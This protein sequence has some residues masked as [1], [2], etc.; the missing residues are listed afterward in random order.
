MWLYLEDR[1]EQSCYQ[2]RFTVDCPT[3]SIQGRYPWEYGSGRV[4]G[5]GVLS[6]L[7]RHSVARLPLG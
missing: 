7:C 4:V 5:T 2:G 6:V 3:D 1:G